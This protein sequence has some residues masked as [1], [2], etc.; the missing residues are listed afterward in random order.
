MFVGDV[1]RCECIRSEGHS[2]AEKRGR[3]P[4]RLIQFSF[5]REESSGGSAIFVVR[6]MGT[7]RTT[8]KKR[9]RSMGGLFFQGSDDECPWNKFVPQVNKQHERDSGPKRIRR[10][11]RTQN[12]HTEQ[13]GDKTKNHTHTLTEPHR[14]TNQHSRE[15][16]VKTSSLFITVS[17]RSEV[18]RL[19][20]SRRYHRGA[21][22]SAN[23][24]KQSNGSRNAKCKLS[25]RQHKTQPKS[26]TI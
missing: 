11:R 6:N 4:T 2:A 22:W 13:H 21:C 19:T 16:E 17:I 10:V 23:T 24:R 7:A 9:Q 14:L 5:H 8:T 20:H 26:L 3:T 18:Y 25:I 1:C 12:G 15:D